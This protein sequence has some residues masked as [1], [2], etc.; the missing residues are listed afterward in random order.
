MLCKRGLC[1]RVV[2]VRLSLWV[3]V[4]FV[5]SVETNK[6]I[7]K[8]RG[9]ECTWGRQKSP[10]NRGV[11]CTWGRRKSP[12]NRG[13]ECTWGMRKS[14]HNRGV[15]CTWGR[16]KFPHNR[17]VECTW[18]RRKSPHNRGVECTWARQKSRFSTNIWL[19]IDDCC[20][21]NINCD[22][23]AVQFTAQTVTHK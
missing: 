20:N 16:R 8:I 2:S 15:E 3:S 22:G 17:G 21:A 13:V 23:A 11:E 7:L 1:R 14:P 10:H 6:R 4:T 19:S 9:V 12:H 5:Y 18:G